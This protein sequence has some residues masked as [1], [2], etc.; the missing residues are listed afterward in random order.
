MDVTT[1]RGFPES[2][3][4]EESYPPTRRCQVVAVVRQVSVYTLA[5]TVPAD[6]LRTT[7]QAIQREDRCGVSCLRRHLGQR[8]MTTCE[9]RRENRRC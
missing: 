1:A 2:T 7:D 9:R 3:T 6:P 5:E 4:I 8:L